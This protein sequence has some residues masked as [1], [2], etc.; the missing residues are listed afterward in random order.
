MI[1]FARWEDLFGAQVC[2][3]REAVSG[4]YELLYD[5]ETDSI[6]GMREALRDCWLLKI[7]PRTAAER[8]VKLVDPW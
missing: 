4:R 3:R 1:S 6:P 8:Y 2:K 5:S 7:P